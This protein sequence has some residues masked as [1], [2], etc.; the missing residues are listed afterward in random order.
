M[1]NPESLRASPAD[2]AKLWK[3]FGVS[4]EREKEGKPAS[5]DWLTHKPLRYDVAHSDV[6]IFLDANSHERFVVNADPN[7]AGKL[8]PSQL[9]RF[10][11]P[12][13]L[14]SLYHPEPVADWTVR[15]GMQVFSWLT[16]QHLAGS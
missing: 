14:K 9:V 15:Q 2:T 10:L 4:Y 7:V 8:P 5:V 3:F 16:N 12:D 6:L 11:N 1:S 13:G